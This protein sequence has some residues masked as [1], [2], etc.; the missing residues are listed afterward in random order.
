MIKTPQCISFNQGQ[1]SGVWEVN[2][3]SGQGLGY[4]FV[5]EVF[6]T[7]NTGYF[8]N[9]FFFYSGYFVPNSFDKKG[10]YTFLFDR[11]KRLGLPFVLYTFLIGPYIE[12]GK[13]TLIWR[14]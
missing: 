13:R 12:F 3:Y 1:S 11:V 9:L 6:I 5:F 8:M 7:T 10:R 14:Q 4:V 2:L